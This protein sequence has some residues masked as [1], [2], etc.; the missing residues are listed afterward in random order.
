MDWILCTY[1]L[2]FRPEMT[3]VLENAGLGDGLN[4]LTNVTFL[5]PTERS[6]S[7]MHRAGHEL[8][9]DQVMFHVITPETPIGMMRDNM[10]LKTAAAAGKKIRINSYPPEDMGPFGLALLTG[11]AHN[12]YTGDLSF[13][14][15]FPD[16]LLNRMAHNSMCF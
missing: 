1:L 12:S 13:S 4:D 14:H 2:L 11:E 8:S 5:I 10:R 16:K 7:K 9:R 3:H 15:I 6:L